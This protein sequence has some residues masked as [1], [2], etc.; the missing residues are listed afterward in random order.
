M[1]A[2]SERRK[3]MRPYI[4]AHMLSSLDG[5]IDSA[6]WI[7]KSDI[8]RD[9]F[10]SVYEDTHRRLAGDAWIVGRTTME[11]FA[12]GDI[13]IANSTRTMPRETFKGA[14]NGPYALVLDPSGKLHWSSNTANG[15]HVIEVLTEQVSDTYLEELQAVGVSYIF[16]GASS[17]DLELAMTKLREEFGIERLLLEGGGRINGSFLAAGLVDEFSLL[18]AP[19]LD[20]T[21]E[22]PASFDR[23]G[24]NIPRR[25]VFQSVERSDNDLLWL[26]YVSPKAA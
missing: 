3:E 20:A 8:D 25:F 7:G 11:E 13:T 9:A 6:A 14:S 17:I 22:T 16:A 24:I 10:V 2:A 21:T 18:L 1:A 23:P 4:I 15:D 12:D 5:R 19:V 26:L